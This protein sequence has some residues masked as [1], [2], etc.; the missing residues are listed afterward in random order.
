M[1]GFAEVRISKILKN[2]YPRWGKRAFD[3]LASLIGLVVL[4]PVFLLCGI[5]V[6]L[7]S[8]GPIFFRQG[9]LGQHGRI[10]RVF[11]FRTMLVGSERLGSMVVVPGDRRLTPL[12][13]LLRR[14]KL[15]EI[16]QL[17]N[18]FLGDMSLVGPRPRV[19]EDFDLEN[20]EEKFLLSVKPGIT[21]YASIYHRMEV[22]YCAQ[23]SDPK[24]AHRERVLPQK[25]YLDS[26]YLENVSLVLDLKLIMLTFLLTL[27]P[28]KGQA[29]TLRFFGVEIRT[30]GRAAQIALEA[31]TFA[32]A[33]WLAYWLRYEGKP[34]EFYQVQMAAFIVL[35][36]TARVI[37]NY[38]LGIYDMMWRYLN[39]VDSALVA[40]SLSLVSAVLLV[41]RFTLSMENSGTRIFV[42]PLG[43]IVMEYLL[44]LTAALGLRGLRQ[45][46]YVMN[47]RYQPLATEKRRRI[48]I[49]GAG[50]SGLGI[51][52]EIGRYPH[53]QL[54]GFVDD[55]PAKKDRLI[56]GYRVLGASG[57]LGELA[58]QHEIS[59]V[60][61][62]VESPL[63]DRLQGLCERCR[64]FGV[65]IHV[66]P[67]VD[68]I[69]RLG[70]DSEE[71][72]QSAQA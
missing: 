2:L 32:S 67:T 6:R 38:V 68:Q 71:K 70:Q 11:K 39:F 14:T 29:Q 58:L 43:I 22:E 13:N 17:I 27:T 53:L 18:V 3:F 28:G 40:L 45:A 46:L 41:F 30:Y 50:L 10:F 66:I 37:C 61:V 51:A 42:I 26:E 15:D 36:P 24:E 44:A 8:H 48:M 54:V 62:C 33:V 16:P 47:H 59:D 56:S 35:I 31:L 34:P 65:K 4:S 52:L 7:T 63:A 5:L 20:P 12:G 21:S 57:Q 19:P 64:G 69:L 23:Q 25:R 60:I 55:D 72:V 49:L 9:R 1:A